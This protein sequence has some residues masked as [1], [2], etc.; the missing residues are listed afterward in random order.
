LK[1]AQLQEAKYY[2][3][4]AIIEWI[5]RTMEFLRVNQLMQAH[6][7]NIDEAIQVIWRE[8]EGPLAI[9]SD[10]SEWNINTDNGK[11]FH[12]EVREKAQGG[13]VNLNRV[14]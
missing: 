5:K 14:L 8:Y 11:L 4:H 3:D 7:D 12:L 13:S 6:V 2:R 9:G 10:Y 1:L